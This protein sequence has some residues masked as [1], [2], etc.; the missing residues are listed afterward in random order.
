MPPDLRLLPYS[1]RLVL[2][3]PSHTHNP[4]C[5]NPIEKP[6]LPDLDSIPILFGLDSIHKQRTGGL[7]RMEDKAVG[8]VVKVLVL[9]GR[10]S[11]HGACG[12]QIQCVPAEPVLSPDQYHPAMVGDDL[13][14]DF[15]KS[16]HHISQRI[17]R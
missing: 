9:L 14:L 13:S 16:K 4:F 11:H 8:I 17:P 15:D 10:F 3:F 6:H 5:P 1:V 2:A 7:L 12:S